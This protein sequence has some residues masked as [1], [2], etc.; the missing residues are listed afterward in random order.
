[1]IHCP[2][3]DLRTGAD[4]GRREWGQSRRRLHRLPRRRDLNFLAMAPRPACIRPSVT[5]RAPAAQGRLVGDEGRRRHVKSCVRH[6]FDARCGISGCS[7][8]SGLRRTHGAGCLDGLH[9]AVPARFGVADRTR[10]PGGGCPILSD[11]TR[12]SARIGQPGRNLALPPNAYVAV[13]RKALREAVLADPPV[14]RASG[15]ARSPHQF[16]QADMT[17]DGA[18]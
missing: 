11:A 14:Y 10:S 12:P 13:E 5:L 1:M 8:A 9:A 3:V 2:E 15:H 17:V 18:G 4:R 16:R 7:T 6:T